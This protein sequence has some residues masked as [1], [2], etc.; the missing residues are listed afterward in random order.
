[1][2]W[3]LQ[4]QNVLRFE[5]AA[6]EADK[7]YMSFIMFFGIPHPQVRPFRLYSSMS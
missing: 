2:I 6:M 4:I 3:H 1:M 7:S 5:T